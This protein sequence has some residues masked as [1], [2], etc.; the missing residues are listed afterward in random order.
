MRGHQPSKGALPCG[1]YYGTGAKNPVGKMR[2]SSLF[3]A[4]DISPKSEKKKKTP[5]A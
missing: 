4:A 5:A 1:D 3:G 2:A